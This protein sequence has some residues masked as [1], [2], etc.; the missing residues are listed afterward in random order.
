MRRTCPPPFQASHKNMEELANIQLKM[1][2][3]V[4][5]MRKIRQ[6]LLIDLDADGSIQ[7]G[8]ILWYQDNPDRQARCQQA[9]TQCHG[10]QLLMMKGTCG[11]CVGCKTLKNCIEDMMWCA[12]WQNVAKPFTSSA[13]V[14]GA[15]SICLSPADSVAKMEEQF[16]KQLCPTPFR[17]EPYI[18]Y[19]MSVGH[20]LR[21]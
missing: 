1:C 15:S 3:A 7:A 8:E 6:A 21:I 10:C 9:Q 14:S 20:F 19:W 18:N 2:Q 5:K 17:P 16:K 13:L 4:R 11:Q 12:S